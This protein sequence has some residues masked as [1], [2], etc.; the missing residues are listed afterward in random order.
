MSDHT[1]KPLFLLGG[2]RFKLSFHDVYCDECGAE[3]D[4]VTVA[5]L[6]MYANDLD[7]EWIALVPAANDAHLE[8]L[9]LEQQRDELLVALEDIILRGLST[10]RI[11]NARSV[12]AKCKAKP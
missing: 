7:G 12:I 5:P 2:M 1:K 6:G 4:E 10:S 9:K 11:N 3:N 8:L